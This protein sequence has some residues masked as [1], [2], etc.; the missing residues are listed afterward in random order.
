MA[1]PKITCEGSRG[2]TQK[3]TPLFVSLFTHSYRAKAERLQHSLDSQDLDYAFYSIP[4]T[5][6]SISPTAPD[7]IAYS[8]PSLIEQL[9][10]RLDRPIVY[11][12]ADLVVC[13]R[14]V[15]LLDLP[16][17]SVD[18]AILNWLALAE[19]DGWSQF[20]EQDN[21]DF[22]TKGRTL[23]RFVVSVDWVSMS[24]LVCSGAV[25][26]WTPTSAA[27]IL[28]QSWKETILRFPGVVDDV[29]LD[30]AFNNLSEDVRSPMKVAWLPK[31][32][33]RYAWWIF[34][35]PVIDHPAFPYGGEAWK[36]LESQ[37]GKSHFY[38]QA[39]SSR[40]VN[41][42]LRQCVLDLDEMKVLCVVADRQL[43]PFGSI[44]IPVFR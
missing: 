29:C 28:L 39:C 7:D 26:Y 32:Y 24:Q 13:D 23:Y 33:C 43:A 25:Q 18:F 6:C 30:Y 4:Q 21:L 8:K 38:T 1:V 11:L 3:N 36:A 41:D 5:H 12:D 17:Q 44:V 31:E 20:T 37:D 35:K 34:D 14:P 19:N 9:L 40:Q 15:L 22:G 10:D 2:G 27:K 16:K 42:Q